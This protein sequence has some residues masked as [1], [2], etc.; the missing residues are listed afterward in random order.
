MSATDRRGNLPIG[1]FVTQPSRCS[2]LAGRTLRFVA[3]GVLWNLCCLH[4]PNILCVFQPHAHVIRH[5]GAGGFDV[6]FQ[7]DA[8]QSPVCCCLRAVSGVHGADARGMLN[9]HFKWTFFALLWIPAGRTTFSQWEFE[10]FP[11]SS[12]KVITPQYDWFKIFKR[13]CLLLYNA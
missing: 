9:R 13:S 5:A 8:H 11:S 3:Q 6:P 4:I 1:A 10:Y 12:R 2:A 7:H